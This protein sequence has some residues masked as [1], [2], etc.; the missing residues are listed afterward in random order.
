MNSGSSGQEQESDSPHIQFFPFP[1][2]GPSPPG[3][4]HRIQSPIDLAQLISQALGAVP[5]TS[6]GDYASGEAFDNIISELTQRNPQSNNVNPASQNAIN[7]IK[8]VR[9]QK[10]GSGMQNSMIGEE[11]SICQEEYLDQDLLV[12]LKCHHIFHEECLLSWVKTNG[13]C[14]ICRAPVQEAVEPEQDDLD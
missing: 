2:G 12:D 5:G 3:H 13:V 10:D 8:R 6:V 1:F 14:P 11:C 4:N 7:H 9:L